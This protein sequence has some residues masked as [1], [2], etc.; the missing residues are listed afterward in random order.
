[1][2]VELTVWR[3]LWEFST[4]LFV[5]GLAASFLGHGRSVWWMAQGI[6]L[7]AVATGF[8]AAEAMHADADFLALAKWIPL[9][10]LASW[11]PGFRI[12]SE[13]TPA[14]EESS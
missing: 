7:L 14:N 2:S 13:T 5:V 12:V 3:P 6:M 11:W 10:W 8:A 4:I 9:V 1:M